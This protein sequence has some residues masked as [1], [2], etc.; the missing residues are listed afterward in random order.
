MWK[1]LHLNIGFFLRC[2][3]IKRSTS[4]IS[5]LQFS[6][7]PF[8]GY[9]RNFP[10]NLWIVVFCVHEISCDFERISALSFKFRWIF[11]L[12]WDNSCHSTVYIA[13]HCH[14]SA[15]FFLF[16]IFFVSSPP[17]FC[18]AVNL[19]K[20]EF[21]RTFLQQNEWMQTT[22]IYK[23]PPTISNTP[24]INDPKR[25]SADHSFQSSS[26]FTHFATFFCFANTDGGA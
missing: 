6:I 23:Q 8:I 16:K 4:H 13:F 3:I 25:F 12:A 7:S 14:S 26:Y 19:T 24:S 9:C 10:C 15:T 11:F 1:W 5:P 20:N 18:C 21:F 17:C 22:P 2:Q